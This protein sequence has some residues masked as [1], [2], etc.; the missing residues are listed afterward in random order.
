MPPFCS[1]SAEMKEICAKQTNYIN[2]YIS[3]DIVCMHVCVCV[4]V[5]V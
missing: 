5:R 2:E 4:H 3:K 1:F